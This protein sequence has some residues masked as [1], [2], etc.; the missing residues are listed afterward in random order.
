VVKGELGEQD[1]VELADICKG[2]YGLA[3]KKGLAPLAE[4]HVPSGASKAPAIS[5]ESIFHQKGVNALAEGQTLKFGP[6]LTIVYGDNGAGKTG[7]TRILKRACQARGREEILGNVISGTAPPKLEVAIKY[8]VSGD[9][10]AREWT[11]GSADAFVSRVSVFDAHCATVYLN[12]KTNV[13]FLPFGLDLFDKLVKAC[14]LVKTLLEADQRA[15]NSDALTAI[16]PTIPEGTAA[17]KLVTGITVVTKPEA[18]TTVTRLTEEEEKKRGQLEQ[19]LKDLQAN[20]PEKF[21]RQLAL[22]AGRARSL[23]QHLKAV[24]SSLVDKTVSEVFAVR[25]NGKIK[26]EEAKKLREAAFPDG[27]LPGTGGEQWKTL[28]D[29]A[30]QFS[31]QQAYPGKAFPVVDDDAQ[32]PLCQQDLE[33]AAVHRLKRFK[34]F[35]ISTA[36][37]EL[38]ELRESFAQ[39]RNAFSS[40]AVKTDAVGETLAEIR[41]DHESVAERIEVAFVQNEKRRV[42][43]VSALG[44]NTDLAADCPALAMSSSLAEGT[45]Q[46]IDGRIKSLQDPEAAAKRNAMT[47]ELREL[48][49]RLLLGKH[50]ATILDEIERKRKYAAY[51]QCLDETKPTAITQKGSAVTKAVVSERLKT[52]F[53]EEL[54]GLDFVHV[55]VELKEAGGTEGVFYHKLVLTRAPNMQLPKVVSEGEQRCLSIAAFFAELSTA[56]DPSGIVFDDPVSSLDVRWRRAVAAR[57]VRESKG[58]QV[59]VFTHDVVFLL[60]LHQA[61]RDMGIEPHDQHVR[62]TPAGAGVCVEE[63]PWA[64][65]A[66]KKRIGH[67]KNEWASVDKLHRDGHQDQYEKEAKNLYGLLREAWERGTEEVLLG[68]VVERFRPGVQTQQITAISDITPDDYKAV[69]KGMS[70]CST[71]LRGHGQAAAAPT[72]VPKPTELKADIDELDNWVK[73]INKRRGK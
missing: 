24:E 52:R 48:N 61:A 39:K 49:A 55:E 67:I 21:V 50:E 28:W 59:I 40:L 64:A 35:V 53:K 44:S 23:A 47:A 9:P 17:A 26:G 22:R 31:E 65:M 46:D 4:E 11:G 57:L 37:T 15:L 29:S 70:K 69:E 7:Y 41:L 5:L 19:L 42:A 6:A 56:D 30:R 51:S 66:V 27:V 62:N 1:I 54:K 71:W 16:I 43:V 18:V 20:D 33:H 73:A 34:E 45:A 60:A 68:G 72:P 3:E 12:D 32:C 58:R 10:T 36:E 2:D 8:K 38:R 13:A 63:L 14:K 25:T